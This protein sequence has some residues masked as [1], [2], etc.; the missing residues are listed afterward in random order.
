MQAHH[1]FVAVGLCQHRCGR[2]VGIFAVALDDAGV[3]QDK[4]RAEAVAIDGDE[5]RRDGELPNGGIHAFERGIENVYLVDTPGRNLGHGPRYGLAFDDC[6]Q[7]IAVAC[8]HLFR[9]V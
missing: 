5:L 8:R 1:V 7:R 3:W 2:N 6:A 4:L 9:V